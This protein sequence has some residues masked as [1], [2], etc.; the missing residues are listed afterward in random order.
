MTLWQ[1][2]RSFFKR[3]SHYQVD[4]MRS[5]RK[6]SYDAQIT[7]E[8][9]IAGHKEKLRKVREQAINVVA[10]EEE[11]GALLAEA[12]KDYDKVKDE[13]IF[14]M[15]K[16]QQE[17]D[18]EKKVLYIEAAQAVAPRV[19]ALES[20]VASLTEQF[21]AAQ[22]QAQQAQNI[23]DDTYA[24][25]EEL[26]AEQLQ[27]E[28]DLKSAEL[29]EAQSAAMQSLTEEIDSG[30]PS[31]KEARDVVRGRLA[32]ANATNRL[33]GG[34]TEQARLSIAREQRADHASSIL[35]KLANE[36]GLAPLRV[37]NTAAPAALP[38]AAVT[39]TDVINVDAA[40]TIQTE[41]E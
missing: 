20:Q 28:G 10:N 24:Q 36:A 38:E 19:A 1:K 9:A 7:I 5:N 32:H 13:A 35:D 15:R 16:A 14:S 8:Q 18:E 17:R 40:E 25:M 39:V 41:K 2:I 27:L 26:Y 30:I 33:A 6:A 22:L 4:K 21:A 37:V 3:E 29:A 11:I 31:L 12:Q 23:S 34:S